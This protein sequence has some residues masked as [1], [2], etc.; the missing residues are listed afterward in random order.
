MEPKWL[1]PEMI[2]ALHSES[3]AR[4]GGS[5][6]LRDHGLLESALERAKNLYSYGEDPSLFELAAIYCAGIVKNHPFVDGNKRAGVLAAA[7]FLELNG[8][9]LLPPETEVVTI[10]LALAAGEI[11][12][13]TLTL[14]ISDNSTPK[15]T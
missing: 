15:R 9:E 14:W 5:A 1:T 7:V 2:V 8:Y 11:E 10:I 6:E 4:F 12:E 3:I 13:D